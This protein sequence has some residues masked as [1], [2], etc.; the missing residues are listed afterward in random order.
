MSD[1]EV[2]LHTCSKIEIPPKPSRKEQ[3]ITLIPSWEQGTKLTKF[4]PEVNSIM[5]DKTG[6]INWVL[7]LKGCNRG[8]KIDVIISNNFKCP[9]IDSITLN[10]T[11]K[12]PNHNNRMYSI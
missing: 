1:F 2:I 9:I 12:P 6:V 7:I 3:I 11:I 4:T 8:E 5:P 10:N